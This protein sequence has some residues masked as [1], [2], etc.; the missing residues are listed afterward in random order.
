MLGGPVFCE[1]SDFCTLILTSTLT[2]PPEPE[3]D[4]P[5]TIPPEDIDVCTTCLGSGEVFVRQDWQTGAYVTEECRTC[6]GSGEY[7]G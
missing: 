2:E 1:D 6:R 3:P 7:P 5:N 4:H